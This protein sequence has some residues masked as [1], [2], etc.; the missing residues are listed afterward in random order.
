MCPRGAETS[1]W[2]GGEWMCLHGHEMFA[3]IHDRRA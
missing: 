3:C 1:P 2:S